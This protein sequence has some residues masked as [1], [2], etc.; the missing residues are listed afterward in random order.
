MHREFQIAISGRRIHGSH[1][2]PNSASTCSIRFHG[3]GHHEIITD[4]PHDLSAHWAI[5]PEIQA[6][7]YELLAQAILDD[8]RYATSEAPP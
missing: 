5:H 3:G 6:R 8:R 4:S 2:Y 1:W 7:V